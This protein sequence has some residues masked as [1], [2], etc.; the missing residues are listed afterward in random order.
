[1]RR[2]EAPTSVWDKIKSMEATAEQLQEELARMNRSVEQAKQR[3]TGGF[4]RSE[5]WEAARTAL[6]DL[7]DDQ[8]IL[9]GRLGTA[10]STLE[11][12]KQWIEELPDDTILELVKV[13][14]DGLDLV[15][16]VTRIKEHKDEIDELSDVPILKKNYKQDIAKYVKSL[17]E[18]DLEGIGPDEELRVIWGRC[19]DMPSLLAFLMPDKMIEALTHLAER[20]ANQHGTPTERKRKIAELRREIVRLQRIAFALGANASRL[21]AQV[22]LGVQVKRAEKRA[23][24]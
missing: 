9:G 14:V 17:S 10:Q 19:S 5:Q 18:P 24:A 7:Q 8:R 16:T 1:M 22:V 21:P 11:T 2:I 23:A 12:C 20:K 13:D 15:R 4:E 6:K 3:L